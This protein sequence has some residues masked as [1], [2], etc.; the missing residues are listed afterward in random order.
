[1][2]NQVQLRRWVT[3]DDF[4]K[5][6]TDRTE[7]FGWFNEIG[8]A[9]KFCISVAIKYELNEEASPII[10]SILSRDYTEMSQGYYNNFIQ[11]S[12][13]DKDNFVGDLVLELYPGAQDYPYKQAEILGRNGLL[14]IRDKVLNEK[15]DIQDFLD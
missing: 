4:L 8:D 13:W 15:W 5:R 7:H 11:I 9:I 3:S 14:F 2:T 1:M 10:D 6:M 12:S